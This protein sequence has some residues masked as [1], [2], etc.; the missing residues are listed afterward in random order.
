ME[1]QEL[2]RKHQA[3]TTAKR[4]QLE[5]YLAQH[6]PDLRTKTQELEDL[7]QRYGQSQKVE[8]EREK[9][10]NIITLYLDN[11]RFT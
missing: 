9:V 1:L 8:R 6:Q 10:S 3:K 5:R 7:S 4:L 11:T 2:L